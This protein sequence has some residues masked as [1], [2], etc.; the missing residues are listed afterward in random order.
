MFDRTNLY[1]KTG[2][3]HFDYVQRYC[4]LIKNYYKD[5][6]YL[7]IN[8]VNLNNR[9][10]L[11]LEQKNVSFAEILKSNPVYFSK[12]IYNQFSKVS[13]SIGFVFKS[14]MQVNYSIVAIDIGT[15][16]KVSLIASSNGGASRTLKVQVL[17]KENNQTALYDTNIVCQN[18]INNYFNTTS[19]K[20]I[21]W[22][23]NSLTFTNG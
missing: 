19:F 6:D 21:L 13:G 18:E 2:D 1:K 12:V 15:F 23:L 9:E 20:K 4:Q 10:T 3:I 8:F 11:R 17:D 7:P 5:N 14:L 22:Y 16:L